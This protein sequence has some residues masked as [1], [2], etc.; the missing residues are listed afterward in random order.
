M[1]RTAETEKAAKNPWRKEKTRKAATNLR[2]QAKEDK[3]NRYKGDLSTLVDDEW[4]LDRGRGLHLL[5][6]IGGFWTQWRREL[7]EGYQTGW[8]FGKIPNG[9]WPSPHFRKIMLQIFLWWIWSNICK[10]VRGP[11]S[12]KRLHM[13][14]RDG[15][16]SEG[17]GLGVNCRLEPI[18]EFIRFGTLTCP[19][20]CCDY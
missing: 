12:M 2:G 9:L 14:S 16:H 3:G 17:W 6:N 13:I 1:E 20:D 7:R 15:D 18:L 5:H 8:F 10:E 19:L 4:G 11:D